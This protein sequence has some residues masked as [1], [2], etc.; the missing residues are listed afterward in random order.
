MSI[1]SHQDPVEGDLDLGRQAVHVL[2]HTN[3]R[4]GGADYSVRVEVRVGESR[5][6]RGFVISIT[7]DGLDDLIAEL[8]RGRKWLV[9]RRA[10][11]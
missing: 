2:R 1:L 5:K 10:L 7:P 4:G 11:T 6:S 9:D 8:E 3:H